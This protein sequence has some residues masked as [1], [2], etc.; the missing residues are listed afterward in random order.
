[1]ETLYLDYETRSCCDLEVRG[2]DNYVHDS[3]T[4]VLL[5]AYAFGE[6]AVKLWQPHLTPMPE[7]LRDALE[8]PFVTAYAWNVAFERE[9]SKQVLGID[10]PTSEWRDPMC[11]ARYLSL[12]G[13]LDAAGE[14]LGIGED[15]AKLKVGN[16][17]IKLF[18]SPE[19]EGG[20]TTLF[21]ISEPTFRDWRTDP[22]DWA[23]FG[24]YCKQ[25]VVAE[26]A[27]LK[28]LDKFPL[29]EFEWDVWQLANKVN[30]SGWPVDMSLVT[31]AREIVVKEMERLGKR[32][33]ELTKL[34]NPN[35]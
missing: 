3:S 28:K 18:C 14:I 10:K 11:N 32:L 2:L 16:R 5:A 15:V 20:E 12:P 27:I 6:R 31:G 9:I 30:R 1:M 22:K 21:G 34:D 8:S 29:P 24:D 35:S 7:D 13:S 19:D 25:D 33:F 26:R 4:Q 23:L 17:L